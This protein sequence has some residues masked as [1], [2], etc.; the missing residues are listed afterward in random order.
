M[1]GKSVSTFLRNPLAKRDEPRDF[2]AQTCDAFKYIPGHVLVITCSA[3]RLGICHCSHRFRSEWPIWYSGQ[4]GS[5]MLLLQEHFVQST[6]VMNASHPDSRDEYDI[7]LCMAADRWGS[8]G[9]PVCFVLC[10]VCFVCPFSRGRMNAS[11]GV[12]FKPTV[13]S[14]LC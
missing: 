12:Y 8:H 10:C 2:R 11:G 4:V 14:W 9:F 1:V 7:N 13:L 3:P 5:A 6:T